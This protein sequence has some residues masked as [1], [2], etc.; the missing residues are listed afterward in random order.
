MVNICTS[1]F[2][3]ENH[4]PKIIRYTVDIEFLHC[5]MFVNVCSLL[6]AQVYSCEVWEGVDEEGIWTGPP[7]GC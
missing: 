1:V 3:H 7:L 5:K 2:N 6:S 4:C